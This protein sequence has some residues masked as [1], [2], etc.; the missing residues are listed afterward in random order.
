[1]GNN[2]LTSKQIELY[3]TVGEHIIE[4]MDSERIKLS[5]SDEN[6]SLSVDD[7]VDEKTQ[8]EIKNEKNP[9]ESDDETLSDFIPAP[10]IENDNQL[11]IVPYGGLYTEL[12]YKQTKAKASINSSTAAKNDP[13]CDID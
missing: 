12:V 5:D 11:S 6:K 1:M 4:I 10:V 9:S 2:I 7:S 13:D 3:G 8:K